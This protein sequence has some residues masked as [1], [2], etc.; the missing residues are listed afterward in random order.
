MLRGIDGQTIAE[1]KESI[2]KH[3]VLQPIIVFLNEKQR[4][5]VICGNHRL[6]AAKGVGLKTIPFIIRQI[7]S[8]QEALILGLNENIQRLEMN[9]FR[10][11]EIY[12]S[13]LEEYS[14][15]VL[16]EKLG[17][18][19]NYVEGR[20]KLFK[21]LHV[22]LRSQVGKTLTLGNGLALARLP[23]SQQLEVYRKITENLNIRPSSGMP[24]GGGWNAP[25][26]YCT[27]EKCGSKHLKGVSV[28]DE[29]KSL[30]SKM[31]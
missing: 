23:Q 21:N 2:K 24:H 22:D 14:I 12:V 9:P 19:R 17:K 18:S 27:C 20:V 16:C 3:G 10:E 29:Q 28:E 15:D 1:L 26:P 13:L 11:G 25:S 8:P 31:Q 4:Y 30:L 7:S 6:C 5:E